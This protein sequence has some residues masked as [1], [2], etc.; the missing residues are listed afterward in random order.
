MIKILNWDV[1]IRIK[2]CIGANIGLPNRQ[3]NKMGRKITKMSH[4]KKKKHKMGRKITKKSHP[5][6]KKHKMGRKITKPSRPTKKNHQIGSKKA[7]NT[8]KK[9]VDV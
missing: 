2:S 9:S 3:I 8:F 7:P 4:P 6:K 5:K 1:E